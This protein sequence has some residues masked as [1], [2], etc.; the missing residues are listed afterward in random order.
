MRAD[1]LLHTV[2]DTVP[3]SL[4]RGH[5]STVVAEL[6]VNGTLTAPDSGTATVYDPA[7]AQ[8]ATGAATITDSVAQYAVAIPAEQT[9]GD[10]YRVEWVLTVG[11]TTYRH[12]T[13][14][15][16]VRR[17]LV[18]PVSVVDLYRVAPQLNASGTDAIT[19]Y[20][21]SDLAAFIREAWLWTLVRLRQSGKRP[22][23]VSGA[24]ALRDCT[25]Q[26]ALAMILGALSMAGAERYQALA[27]AHDDKAAH[28]FRVA[29]LEYAPDDDAAE[30][31]D[32]PVR[33]AS[34][35]FMGT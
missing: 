35:W 6:Y 29:R 17:R 30:R 28:A 11:S 2:R 12:R 21:A 15:E 7:G 25:L 1:E 22:D 33:P 3:D 26:K 34:V 8:V 24:D 10:M 9:L 23:L 5:T 19:R 31:Q 13:R 4:E 20:S 27:E 14:A 32:R 18:C 16:V